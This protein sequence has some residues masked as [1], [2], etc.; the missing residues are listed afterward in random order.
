MQCFRDS[1]HTPRLCS[2][3]DALSGKFDQSTRRALV[4]PQMGDTHNLKDVLMGIPKRDLLGMTVAV[5]PIMV[6]IELT[7]VK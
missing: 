2:R 3:S 1:L 7:V 4:V 6:T 5:L